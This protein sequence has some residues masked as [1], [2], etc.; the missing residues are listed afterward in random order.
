MYTA[1]KILLY[2]LSK[3]NDNNRI[4]RYFCLQI[5]PKD[6]IEHIL[7]SEDMWKAY[8]LNNYLYWPR[9]MFDIR[10]HREG[11]ATIAGFRNNRLDNS[12]RIVCYRGTF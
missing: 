10:K 9:C 2:N 5:Y 12:A 1:Y 8:M 4:F 7:Y 6:M 11:I 3:R